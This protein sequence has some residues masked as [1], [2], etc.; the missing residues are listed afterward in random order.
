MAGY[1]KAGTFA[2]SLLFVPLNIS[3]FRKPCQRE[4]LCNLE[5]WERSPLKYPSVRDLRPNRWAEIAQDGLERRLFRGDLDRSGGMRLNSHAFIST[6]RP[7]KR[8]PSASRRK[9]CSIAESPLNLISPP[10]P[11]TRCHGN[12][13]PRLKIAATCLAAP[14]NP[15]TRAIAP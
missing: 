11:S 6:R 2:R 14:G 9:R 4:E 3:R 1:C 12:P 8:T 7:R 13:N 10:A 15:A 5:K